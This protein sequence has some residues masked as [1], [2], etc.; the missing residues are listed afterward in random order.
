M[1]LE[2]NVSYGRTI[3]L[4]NYE[5]TRIQASISEGVD[6]KD[7]RSYEEIFNELFDECKQLVLE[8]CELEKS[9]SDK[10]QDDDIQI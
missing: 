10:K 6:P 3:N 5:L 1:K 7:N 9:G 2:I 8:K 4:G